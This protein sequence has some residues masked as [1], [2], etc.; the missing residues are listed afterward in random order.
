MRAGTAALGLTLLLAGCAGAG[1]G[2]EQTPTGAEATGAGTTSASIETDPALGAACTTFW[3]DPDYTDPLSRT[4]L[5]RAGTAPQAGPSDPF[6]YEMA[7]DDIDAAFEGAPAPAKDA[8]GVL[9]EW[10]RTQPELGTDGGPRSLPCSME[11]RRRQL[12]RGVHGR[13]LGR[14]RGGE[15]GAKPAALVCAEVFD[16]PGTLTHFANAN[17]LTSNMFKLVGLAPREVPGDRMGEVQSTAELLAAQI[18][19]V[20][21]DAVGAALEQVRAPF[22]EALE[23]DAWSDGLEAPLAEL[24]TACGAAGYSSPEPG[25]MD[26]SAVVGANAAREGGTDHEGR[27]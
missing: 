1:D 24:G 4:V 14:H 18:A 7:G 2:A 17:V 19:A 8:A 13:E 26:N 12:R 21:D 3:G 25:E 16:T 10:F 6:F 23:G 9:S 20:D 22:Q 11:G 27:S 15:D 5:D